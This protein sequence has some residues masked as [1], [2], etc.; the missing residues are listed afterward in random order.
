[1]RFQMCESLFCCSQANCHKPSHLNMTEEVIG[2][3]NHYC[4]AS[5]RSTERYHLLFCVEGCK[6]IVRVSTIHPTLPRN[7]CSS[8]E[9][10]GNDESSTLVLTIQFSKTLT[11]NQPGRQITII[12]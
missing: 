4:V 10:V 8:S 12:M 3:T 6:V 2:E 5:V 1:M 9:D 7:R 11:A